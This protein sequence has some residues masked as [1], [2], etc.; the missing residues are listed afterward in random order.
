MPSIAIDARKYFDFGIGSYIQNLVASLSTLSNDYSFSLY[1]SEGDLTRVPVPSGWA[2]RAC[3]YRKYSVGELFFFQRE[4]R[5]D[6]IDLFHEPHYT[7]P[8]G[9]KGRSVVTV[10]DLIHLKF[11]QFF[12]S[13]QRAYASF[14]LRKAARE[15]GGVIAVSRTTK[16][17]LVESF[18]IPADAVTVV[19]NGIK[20]VF[21]KLEGANY[22]KLVRERVGLTRPYLLF[23]GNIKPHKNIPTLLR[24]LALTR[25]VHNDVCLA[26][27]GGSCLESA[28]LRALVRELRLTDAVKDLGHLPDA[29]LLLAYNG[30]SVLVLPSLYEGF[31]FP[32]LEAMACGTPVVAS[33]GGSLPE[34]VGDAAILCDPTQPEEFSAAIISLLNDSRKSANLVRRGFTQA[35]RFTWEQ[36]AA[37]TLDVYS[38]VIQQCRK[39]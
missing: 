23:V 18:G 15:A 32:V 29:D 8:F 9:L 37:G 7:L 11:P 22:R 12:S 35:A 36:S 1:L 39:R 17:D 13:L 2:R 30:A 4:I 19:Y 21:R 28:S 3:L 33:T 14:V 24:A 16:E 20:P 27:A 38:K 26:F 6:N 34:V 31:G 25:Q 5:R 10:H